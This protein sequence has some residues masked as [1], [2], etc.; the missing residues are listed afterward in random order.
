MIR[1]K[2]TTF[3]ACVN[4]EETLT[5]RNTV[6]RLAG[7]VVDDTSQFHFPT[8]IHECPLLRKVLPNDNP[9]QTPRR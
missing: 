3:A 2:R 9:S 8:E 1:N 7:P 4:S 6:P 5:V